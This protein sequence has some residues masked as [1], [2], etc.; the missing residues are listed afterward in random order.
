MAALRASTWG[1]G[2]G[3]PG[4]EKD[5]ISDDCTRVGRIMVLGHLKLVQFWGP[6]LRKNTKMIHFCKCYKAPDS[7]HFAGAP[8]FITFINYICVHPT[9]MFRLGPQTVR[10]GGTDQETDAEAQ[11]KLG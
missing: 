2:R 1:S 3:S 4:L 6:T 9:E 7:E 5:G 8:S 11:A 10:S